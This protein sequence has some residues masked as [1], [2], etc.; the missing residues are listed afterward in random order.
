VVAILVPI[1]QN[2]VEWPEAKGIGPIQ[3]RLQRV[4]DGV[5]AKRPILILTATVVLESLHTKINWSM[6]TPSRCS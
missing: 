1:Q 3:E 4:R 6:I 5:K 2:L